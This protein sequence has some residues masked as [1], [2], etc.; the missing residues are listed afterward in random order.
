MP[1]YEIYYELKVQYEKVYEAAH[2]GD[3]WKQFYDDLRSGRLHEIDSD[4]V[5]SQIEEVEA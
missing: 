3:A 5:Y 4:E 2:K 1:K